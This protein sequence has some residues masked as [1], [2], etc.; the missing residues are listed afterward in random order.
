[1]LLR[2]PTQTRRVVIAKGMRKETMA[3]ETS[4]IGTGGMTEIEGMIG[5]E[6]MIEIEGTTGTDGTIE[7]G[8]TIDT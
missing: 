6:E 8:V 3:D 7:I 5:T 1:M 2:R 4:A